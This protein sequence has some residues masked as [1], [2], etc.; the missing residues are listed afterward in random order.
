VCGVPIP[1]M[2]YCFRRGYACIRASLFYR[3]S[4]YLPWPTVH[5]IL[6][7]LFLNIIQVPKIDPQFK[8]GRASAV[9][10]NRGH[11]AGGC[12]PPSHSL[13]FPRLADVAKYRC[14]LDPAAFAICWQ[15]SC[16]SL[17]RGLF[18]SLVLGVARSRWTLA[19]GQLV[20][21]FKIHMAP[22]WPRL[23]PSPSLRPSPVR[24]SWQSSLRARPQ[25][26]AQA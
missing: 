13:A 17:L 11:F 23:K 3:A 4:S 1:E 26:R 14:W 7:G 8:A 21:G 22:A 16:L 5:F 9:K 6:V 18:W 19:R 24:R 12:G 15:L 20:P 10:H 25:T 2:C